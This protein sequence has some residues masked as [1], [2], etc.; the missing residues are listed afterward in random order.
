MAAVAANDIDVS[1]AHALTLSN[2]VKLCAKLL[3][4]GVVT[5]PNLVEMIDF[6][7]HAEQLIRGRNI[8]IHGRLYQLFD[9][10]L[11]RASTKHSAHVPA[12]SAE[13][14]DLATALRI[15]SANLSLIALYAAPTAQAQ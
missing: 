2:K 5:C 14:Y 10:P 3:K 6:L 13:M 1:A 9:G 7:R 8:A 4:R 12:S 15:G 11:M